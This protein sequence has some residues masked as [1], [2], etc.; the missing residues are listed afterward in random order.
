[1]AMTFVRLR[2]REEKSKGIELYKFECKVPQ[3]FGRKIRKIAAEEH[4]TLAELVRRTMYDYVTAREGETQEAAI[5]PASSK[6][7]LPR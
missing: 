1:M 7:C 5:H 6:T 4:I 2:T 3:D